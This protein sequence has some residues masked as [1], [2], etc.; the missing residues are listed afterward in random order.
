MAQRFLSKDQQLSVKRVA[1][2]DSWVEEDQKF[3]SDHDF[4]AAAMALVLGSLMWKTKPA[5][6]IREKRFGSI[7]QI[8]MQQIVYYS[9]VRA[10]KE[11]S[12]DISDSL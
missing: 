6:T 2:A 1:G 11:G 10:P 7:V 5:V 4:L 9:Q 12:L 8:E 3:A